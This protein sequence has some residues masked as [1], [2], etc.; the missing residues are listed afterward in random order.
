MMY[1]ALQYV[2]SNN[3]KLVSE[4]KLIYKAFTYKTPD[5]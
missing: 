3:F 5:S 2:F 4:I 1:R